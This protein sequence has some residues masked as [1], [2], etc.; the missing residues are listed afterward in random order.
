MTTNDAPNRRRAAIGAVVTLL[1]PWVRATAAV[2]AVP[3]EV[4]AEQPGA[5]LLGSG[6]LRV[7]GF[8]V[9]DARLWAATPVLAAN[10][11]SLPL[12]LE[13]IYARALVGSKIV[14]R[15]LDEMRLQ[16]PVAADVAQRW[17]TEMAALFPD[18]KAGDRL[19]GVQ[20]PG[21]GTRFFFNGSLRGE[22]RDADF[23]KLFFGIWLSPRSSQPALRDALLGLPRAPS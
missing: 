19:S 22:V 2:P 13:V 7:L 20:R 17:R 15:T 12:T 1:L 11:A 3:T 21:E 18:V 10:F 16:A 8:A 6:R 14:E 9:Y 4:L 23:T 5:R